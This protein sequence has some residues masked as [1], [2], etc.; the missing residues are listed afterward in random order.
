M[1]AYRV[2]ANDGA[3][4]LKQ[5]NTT[6]SDAE[7]SIHLTKSSI[8]D[9]KNNR[10]AGECSQ[11]E[12]TPEMISAGRAVLDA[13]MSFWEVKEGESAADDLVAEIYSAM[14]RPKHKRLNPG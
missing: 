14:R 6:M 4:G 10:Q 12:I 11:T 2:Q 1:A 9:D 13:W 3:Y 7:G 8:M 5:G